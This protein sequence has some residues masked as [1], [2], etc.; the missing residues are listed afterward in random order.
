MLERTGLFAESWN[1]AWREADTG[2]IL[3]DKAAEF[4]V[5]KNNI[6]YWAADPFPFKYNG[7][8]YIFAELYDYVD[9]R[10]GIGYC[11][12]NGKSFGKW[13]KV[14]SESYH[15]SYPFI[16]EK[17]NE[18]FIM[19]ESGADGSVY[20]YRA[21]EFPDK[22][23]KDKVLREGVVYGD[24]TPFEYKGH[25]YALSYDVKN[26]DEYNL[27]LLDLA[28]ESFDKALN[29][30]SD[31]ELRRPA[32]KTFCFDNKH[33]RP[34]QCCENSYGE[35][36][37]FYEFELSNGNYSEIMLQRINPQELIYSD[38]ILLD[39]MHTYNS[40]EG[41]EVID[42]KTRRFNIINFIFRIIGKIRKK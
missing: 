12:W 10:G 9:C 36:L 34:A 24:T 42:I 37:A 2:A 3:T 15:L 18:V 16:F 1:V 28:D 41:I 25:G 23:A 5:I 33:I 21:V 7:E 27:V 11:K 35:G 22:W 32:G 13:K 17:D 19:P 30:L 40:T 8:L 20:L 38:K 31:P 14:I 26:R 6:R 39:G 29:G 4:R